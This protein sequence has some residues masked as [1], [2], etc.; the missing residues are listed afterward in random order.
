MAD[1]N[2]ARSVLLFSQ[3]F[4]G[5]LLMKL[6]HIADDT[7]QPPT[8]CVSRRKIRYHPGFF[9]SLTLGE[10]VFV[11]AHEVM[12]MVYGHLPRIESFY[13][14]GVGPDG[15]KFD[16][17]KFNQACDYPLNAALVEMKVGDPLPKDKFPMC[18]DPQKY[19]SSMTPEEVYCLMPD[20]DGQGGAAGGEAL[21]GHDF[22]V[23]PGDVGKADAITPSDVMQAAQIHKMTRGELPGVIE[24]L[25]GQLQKPE[26]SPWKM[27]RQFVATSVAGYDRTTW[28]RLQCRMIV[29]RIGMPGRI[30]SGA[31]KVGVVGDVSGSID[32]DTLNLFAGHMA[33]IMDDARP[34]EVRVYWT[35]THVRRVDV[36]KS[37]VDLRRIMSNPIPGGGGTDMPAGVESALADGCDSVVVLTDGMTPFGTPSP[38]PVMWAITVASKVA[39]HGK[40]IHI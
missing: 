20:D 10:A 14:S 22:E 32:E 17:R 5:T 9:E 7:L 3:P 4:F 2:E 11:L 8:A 36:A 37:G 25:I 38:K 21:D 40:T 13:K 30:A 35:D 12:H 18:L 1:F 28:K 26:H 19:P 24:R 31:G 6:D 27:L 33:A 29:R 39:P 16:M 34:A 15:K 23:G